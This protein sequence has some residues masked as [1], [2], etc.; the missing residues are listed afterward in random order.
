[1]ARGESIP[2][3]PLDPH[4]DARVV[5]PVVKLPPDLEVKAACEKLLSPAERVRFRLLYREEL[6]N[7]FGV[8]P[9]I[10]VALRRQIHETTERL[11]AAL[12][13]AGR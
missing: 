2:V 9:A 13:R 12:E 10:R 7:G 5:E 1:M 3:V 6:A 8:R 11:E 4:A